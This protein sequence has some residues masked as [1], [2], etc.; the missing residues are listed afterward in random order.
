VLAVIA[1]LYEK[2]AENYGEK[3]VFIKQARCQKHLEIR[4]KI[5]C[6]GGFREGSNWRWV[7]APCP[8]F[9]DS[10]AAFE[11]WQTSHTPP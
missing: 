8:A 6:V 4:R 2:D 11:R 10:I 5:S 1:S 3:P 9:F 7:T